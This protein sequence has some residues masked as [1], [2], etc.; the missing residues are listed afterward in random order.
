MLGVVTGVTD[1][2]LS[3]REGGETPVFSPLLSYF[4]SIYYKLIN[5]YKLR[6]IDCT[7]SEKW[8]C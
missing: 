3:S 8:G 5:N 2:K 7:E 6:H 1:M 4:Q